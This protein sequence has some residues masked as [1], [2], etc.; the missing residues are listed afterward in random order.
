MR[1]NVQWLLMVISCNTVLILIFY[2]V[3]NWREQFEIN[4]CKEKRNNVLSKHYQRYPARKNMSDC[5]KLY[6]EITVLI[7]Y[8]KNS[9]KKK[10]FEKNGIIHNQ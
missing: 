8:D 1:T 10:I 4:F 2:T 5:P 9:I 7:V 6:G 3:N